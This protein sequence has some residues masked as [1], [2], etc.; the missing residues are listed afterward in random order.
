MLP[1]HWR[2][3]AEEDLNNILTYIAERS[4]SGAANLLED[5]ERSIY[6]ISQNPY[7]Y[8]RGRVSG[9]REIVAHPNYIIVYQETLDAI[10]IVAILHSRQQYP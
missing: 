8:R 7:L 3:D 5:I 9:T 10:E 2:R 6:G 1:I 4:P